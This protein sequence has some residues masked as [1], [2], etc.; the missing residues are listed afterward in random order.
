MIEKDDKLGSSLLAFVVGGLLFTALSGAV[1][2]WAGAARAWGSYALIL[3]VL[4]GAA[5]AA[6]L[7]VFGVRHWRRASASEQRRMVQVGT[8]AMA[9]LA[10]SMLS[11]V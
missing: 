9:V 3:H 6:P 10:A 7:A 2:P 1:L 4:A 11:G 8:A 5:V